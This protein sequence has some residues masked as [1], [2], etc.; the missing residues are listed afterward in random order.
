[1]SAIA[2]LHIPHFGC[3]P[4]RDLSLHTNKV[5]IVYVSNFLK[6]HTPLCKLFGGEIEAVALMSDVVV[7]AKHTAEVAPGKENRS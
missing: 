1:M 6:L 3:S 5:D 2:P 4:A 7:L